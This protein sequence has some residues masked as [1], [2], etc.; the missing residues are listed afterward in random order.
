MG[1]FERTLL[2]SLCAYPPA[3][4]IQY[5]EWIISPI[6]GGANNRLLRASGPQGDYAL[7][8][9]RQDARDRAGREY[10]ALQAIQQAHV[11]QGELLAPEPLVLVRDLSYPL[12]IQH[13]LAGEALSLSPAQDEE[14]MRLLEHYAAIHRI[15]PVN[16]GTALADASLNFAS[17]AQG[18]S[19]VHAQLALLPEQ[20]HSPELLALIARLDAWCAPDWPAPVRAL[21]RTD[22]N[23]RNFIQRPGCWASVDWENS[24]WGDPAFDIA[25]LITHAA[26]L[27]VSPQRWAWV[28]ERYAQ[29]VADAGVC[30]RIES[31]VVILLVWWVVRMAR[32]RYEL[33]RGLDTRL[34]PL[35]EGW[36]AE[37]IVKQQYYAE[38]AHAALYELGT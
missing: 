4:P 26:Y 32:Y 18:R 33:P 29:L 24:G 30:Q 14:W 35:P 15:Q 1:N 16:T 28:R 23:F 12:V 3:E 8:F 25:D 19:V 37:A 21:C 6:T 22:A 7:K 10:A 9:M 13:W 27:D 11:L 34:V 20:E 38:K 17:V 36:E 5:G 2:Q 31:Y